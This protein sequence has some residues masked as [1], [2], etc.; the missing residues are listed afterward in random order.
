MSALGD[1]LKVVG[2]PALNIKSSPG[3]LGTSLTRSPNLTPLVGLQNKLNGALGK[4]GSKI[5]FGGNIRFSATKLGTFNTPTSQGK[6]SKEAGKSYEGNIL[7]PYSGGQFIRPTLFKTIIG[8]PVKIAVAHDAQVVSYSC[9][10]CTLPGRRF[11]TGDARRGTPIM[12]KI[13]YDVLYPEVNMM[14]QVTKGM[15][16]RAL[17]DAWQDIIYNPITNVFGYPDDYMVDV[18]I[19]QLDATTNEVRKYTLHEAFPV[20]V[21]EIQLAWDAFDQIETFTTSWVYKSWSAETL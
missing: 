13:P 14:F 9:Q 2:I 11:S 4:L 7:N 6:Y 12:Q 21:G 20:A 1:V 18:Y 5:P 8:L 10:N 15:K 16:E 3:G 17:F 19:I